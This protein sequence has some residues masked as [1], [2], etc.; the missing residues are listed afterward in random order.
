M[1]QAEARRWEI[2][3]LHK[4][5]SCILAGRKYCYT[6][7]RLAAVDRI[8]EDGDSFR[9]GV[10]PRSVGTETSSKVGTLARNL[11]IFGVLLIEKS[12]QN[13]K[14]LVAVQRGGS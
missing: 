8:D 3:T 14:V 5:F 10:S 1:A 11:K 12:C 9:C 6:L 2:C 4:L 13:R 7:A